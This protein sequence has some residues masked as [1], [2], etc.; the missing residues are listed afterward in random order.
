MMNR[1][2]F[3]RIPEVITCRLD[4]LG[5]CGAV[6]TVQITGFEIVDSVEVIKYE[7]AD[8]LVPSNQRSDWFEVLDK[9]AMKY[10]MANEEKFNDKLKGY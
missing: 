3:T 8:G 2:E 4:D 10:V 9:I 6:L 1:R 7:S 5:I